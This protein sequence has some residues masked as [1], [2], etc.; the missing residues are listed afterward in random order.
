MRMLEKLVEH[1]TLLRR[2]GRLREARPLERD[3]VGAVT[4]DKN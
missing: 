4:R 1:A 2:E 3:I